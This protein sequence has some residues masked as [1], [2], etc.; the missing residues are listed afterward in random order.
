MKLLQQSRCGMMPLLL[1]L[2]AH[3]AVLWAYAYVQVLCVVCRAFVYFQLHSPSLHGLPL[4]RTAQVG[5]LTAVT[6]M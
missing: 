4:I 5:L 2:A 3:H 6:T 1:R